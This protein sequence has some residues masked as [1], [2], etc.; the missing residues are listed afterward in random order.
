MA[1]TRTFE[2]VRFRAAVGEQA[3]VLRRG[4]TPEA[5][6]AVAYQRKM[7][8]LRAPLTELFVVFEDGVNLTP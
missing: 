7:N 6:E 1:P 5:R 4:A 3:D 8:L 2:G